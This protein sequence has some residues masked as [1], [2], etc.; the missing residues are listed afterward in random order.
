M[1]QVKDDSM[2]LRLD[3]VTSVNR[4]PDSVFR[5]LHDP[6]TLLACVP[7]ATLTRQLGPRAF[8]ARIVFGVGPFKVAQSGLGWIVESDPR[9]RTAVLQVNG[10][11][12][13]ALPAIHMHTSMSVLQRGKGSEIRMS[14]QISIE[15]RGRRLSRAWLDPIVCDVLDRTIHRIKERLE[16]QP[17]EMPPAA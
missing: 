6:E 14:F 2:V 7:G 3:G 10:R 1:V 9:A 4:D 17:P 13:A 11:E 8:E 5:E 16:Q 15:D 12:E